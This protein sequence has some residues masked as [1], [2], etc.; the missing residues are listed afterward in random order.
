M[1]QS[2]ITQIVLGLLAMLGA[3]IGAYV[4]IRTDLARLHERSIIT[5]S[6]V[7]LA[8]RRIDGLINQ[9]SGD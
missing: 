1:D 5:T 8:H 9:R 2:T 4:A 6:M 3:C 7:D